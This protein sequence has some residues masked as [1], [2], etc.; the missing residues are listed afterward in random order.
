MLSEAV[1]KAH[2]PDRQ[3]AQHQPIVNIVTLSSVLYLPSFYG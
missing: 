2:M 3:A 1:M